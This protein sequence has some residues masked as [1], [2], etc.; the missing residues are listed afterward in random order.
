VRRSC[1]LGLN[2]VFAAAWFIGTAMAGHLPR[3]MQMAGTTLWRCS[4]RRRTDRAHAG[5]EP[6]ARVRPAASRAS[7]AVGAPWVTAGLGFVGFV[8]PMLLHGHNAASA[9]PQAMPAR[10]SPR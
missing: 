1:G 2:F 3:R 9:T 10:E 4:D 7:A 8:A 5:G 6:A